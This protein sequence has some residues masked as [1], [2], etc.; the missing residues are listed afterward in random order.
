[1]LAAWIVLRADAASALY[2]TITRA[3]AAPLGW[4]RDRD[5]VRLGQR[6]TG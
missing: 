1:V 4:A 6:R 3:V 2:L 5:G